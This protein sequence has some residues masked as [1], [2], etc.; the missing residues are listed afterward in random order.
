MHHKVHVVEQNPV[1]LAAAL[2]GVGE[3]AELLLEPVLDLVGDGN[4]LAV[5]RGRGDQKK[6][7]QARV[8]RVQFQNAGI[9]AFFVFTDRR[10]GL[11]ENA[12]LLLGFGRHSLR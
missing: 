7:R 8:N 4:G 5:V 3:N 11:N 10:G 1:A 12:C 6:V 9:L 2:N